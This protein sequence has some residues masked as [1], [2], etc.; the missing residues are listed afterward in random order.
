VTDKKTDLPN[1][2]SL[3]THGTWEVSVAPDGLLMLPRHLVP[4]EVADFV[5]AIQEAAKVGAAKQATAAAEPK[6][7]R[8]AASVTSTLIISDEEPPVGATKLGNSDA[9]SFSVIGRRTV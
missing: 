3:V 7:A 4:S 5:A 9:P 2:W 8:S 1:G 6:S